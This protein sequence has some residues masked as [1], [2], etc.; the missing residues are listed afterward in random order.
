MCKRVSAFTLVELLV[1]IAIIGVLIALLLP[2][3]QAAREAARRTS[4]FNNL[5][6]T[7]L[8]L[9]NHHDTTGSLPSGWEGADPASGEPDVEGEPGWGWASRILPFIELQNVAATLVKYELPVAHP[10]N[11]QAREQSLTSFLCPSDSADS[12]FRIH[13]EDAPDTVLV[14]LPTS[15]YVGVFGT[16]E[17]DECEGLPVG[18]ICKGDGAFYHLSK[19][20]VRDLVD[21][22]S[23]TA[24]IGERS[25]RKGYSTWTGVIAGGEE[26]M[27]RILGITDHPPNYELGHLDD[28]RSEHPGGANFVFADGSVHFISDDVDDAAYRA[29]A[30]ING[31]EIDE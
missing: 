14:Q 29:M 22:L 21:G 2:A 31:G 9:Q 11:R 4:C 17:L 25:T 19:V 26:A 13:A 8:A 15:N 28:F 5:R 12:F 20:R 27:A 1:V 16:L 3:V 23:K 7:G 18:T 24:V 6:Q 10:A 30:T